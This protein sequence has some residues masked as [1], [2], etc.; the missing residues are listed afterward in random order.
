MSKI[1]TLNA[2]LITKQG[3]L[4]K[5]QK[6]VAALTARIAALT[7]RIANIGNEEAFA[8]ALN[9]DLVG[10]KVTFYF[11]RAEKRREMEGTVIAYRAQEGRVGAQVKV[12]SG[13]GFEASLNTVP[14]V[15]L[16]SVEGIDFKNVQEEDAPAE[17]PVSTDAPVDNTDPLAD[18]PAVDPFAPVQ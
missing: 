4:A 8:E 15:A 5:A 2:S 18:V 12:Q 1:E 13:G 11:G 17:A 7:A 16:I 14:V 3:Q 10:K 6:R 9:R